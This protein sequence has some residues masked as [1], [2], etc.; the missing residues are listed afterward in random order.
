MP[1]SSK[2]TGS[3]IAGLDATIPEDNG[4]NGKRTY[5]AAEIRKV[6]AELQAQFPNFAGATVTATEAELN[7]CDITTLGTAENSK[8]LTIKGDS[9]WTVAGMTCADL[10]TVTTID[11][12]G[13]TAD[14]MVIGGA[15]AA[16][17]T[18]T[19]LTANTSITLTNAVTEFSTDGTLSGD[20]DSA[21]PTEKAVKTYVDTQVASAA[22]VTE[23]TLTLISPYAA[24]TV[25][26]GQAHSLGAVPDNLYVYLECTATDAGYA[27]GDMVIPYDTKY[28]VVADAT[29]VTG[30]STSASQYVAHKSTGAATA[31]TVSKWKLMAR[32]QVFA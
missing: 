2:D 26:T 20:S 9:T 14:G 22:S 18:V 1:L 29:N 12:N 8:A 10:G 17:A 7:Y 24:S 27:V 30:I 5:G 19:T 16:A 6:K 15:S 11:I 3:Y 4:T 23:A 28:Q 21:L 31:I 25:G 32:A 13:G